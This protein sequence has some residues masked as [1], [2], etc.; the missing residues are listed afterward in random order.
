MDYLEGRLPD[1]KRAKVERHLVDCDACLEAIEITKKMLHDSSV[2]ELE[3]VPDLITSRVVKAVKALQKNPLPDRIAGHMSRLTEKLSDVLSESL[4]MRQPAL[5]LVRGKETDEG[6]D[7]VVLKNSF[8]DLDAE[9][10]IEKKDDDL[11]KIRVKATKNGVEIKPIRITL[12]HKERE[13]A[14]YLDST[15]FFENISFGHYVLKFTIFAEQGEKII[16]Y[17]FEI[18]E[19]GD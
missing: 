4:T 8:P 2:S 7:L 9:I 17:P 18:R 16:E 3:P 14:S 12:F 1:K 5:V 11:L 19:N 13:V 6:E 15:A 10:E